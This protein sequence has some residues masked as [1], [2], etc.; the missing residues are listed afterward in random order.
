MEN[1]LL[2]FFRHPGTDEVLY[3]GVTKNPR[4]RFKDH[5]KP[6][7]NKKYVRSPFKCKLQSLHSQGYSYEELLNSFHI[8]VSHL[9]EDD[10]YELETALIKEHHSNNLTNISPGGL[11]GD[12]YTNHPDRPAIIEKLK[13]RTPWNKG[14]TG[15]KVN[16]K[17]SQKFFPRIKY[18]LTSPSGEVYT[19]V[20]KDELKNFCSNWNKSHGVKWSNDKNWLS[21]SAFV[22]SIK[23]PPSFK[24]SLK[25]WNVSIEYL[26]ME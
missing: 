7:K 26:P 24:G 15:Y 1:H 25:G 5:L 10:A 17:T 8:I 19:C 18:I 16:N 11:G 4:R 12:R 2:Y 14:L 6:V 22:L 13:K 9:T 21:V 23:K 20:G 3:I